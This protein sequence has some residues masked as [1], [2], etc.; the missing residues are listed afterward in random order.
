MEIEKHNIPPKVPTILGFL[1]QQ[2]KVPNLIEFLTFTL[3]CRIPIL[4]EHR[5][6]IEKGGK[7]IQVGFNLQE[8]EVRRKSIFIDLYGCIKFFHVLFVVGKE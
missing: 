8:S 5:Q 6:Y 3:S 1:Q 4:S 2:N 7:I